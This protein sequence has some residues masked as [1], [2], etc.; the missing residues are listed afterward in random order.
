MATSNDSGAS[1]GDE[2][3]TSEEE[4]REWKKHTELVR[5]RGKVLEMG[6]QNNHIKKVV[7]KAIEIAIIMLFFNIDGLNPF[8]VTGMDKIG[9][10]A[11]KDAADKLGYD[12][13]G[14]IL[15]RL[16][17]GSY[18][19]YVKHMAKLVC[20]LLFECLSSYSDVIVGCS[21]R[22]YLPDT[23]QRECEGCCHQRSGTRTNCR[24]RYLMQAIP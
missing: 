4:G 8:G 13:E 3:G 20:P 16:Q 18:G 7:H 21:A 17:S 15:D 12:E 24:G 9:H 1:T 22:R 11:L 2:S 6:D 10:A 23:C 5:G 14:D 19:R